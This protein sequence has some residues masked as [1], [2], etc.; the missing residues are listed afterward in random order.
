MPETPRPADQREISAPT[1]TAA[2][3]DRLRT[4]IDRGAAGDK[5]GFPDPA[6]TPLG[7]DAEAGGNPAT[8]EEVELAMEQEMPRPNAKNSRAEGRP[9]SSGRPGDPSPTRAGLPVTL[10]VGAVAVIVVLGIV[11]TL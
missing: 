7:T 10:M 1:D 6:S 11:L 4:E 2:T 3:T 5:I 9:V 8:R